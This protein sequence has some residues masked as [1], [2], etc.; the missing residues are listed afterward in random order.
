MDY[1]S[2]IASIENL[3]MAFRH[4]ASNRGGPGVDSV[5]IEDFQKNQEQ[6]IAQISHSLL[7]GTY[8][9]QPALGIEMHEKKRMVFVL[10]VSDRT[11][12]QA[13]SQ[14][15]A[16]PL[17]KYFH[18][19]CY[20]YRPGR[21]AV[22]AAEFLQKKL[23]TNQFPYILRCDI[24]KYFDHIDYKILFSFLDWALD[25]KKDD[26][27]RLISKLI[28]QKRV[29]YGQLQEGESGLCQGSSLSP[30][31]SNLYL[32]PLDRYLEKMGY[33]HV[34][35]CDDLTVLLPSQEEAQP[36]CSKISEF[37]EEYLKLKLHPDKL[38]LACFSQ[39]FDFLGFHFSPQGRVPSQKAQDRLSD[40]VQSTESQEE[41]Q[42]A[43]QHWEA[44]YGKGTASESANSQASYP[45]FDIMRSLFRGNSEYF[46]RAYKTERRYEYRAKS[47]KITDEELMGH[48][49]GN[50]TLG[51]YLLD[52]DKVAC[53]CLDLDIE[54]Q[55]MDT[56]FHNDA[57][58]FC[59]YE[60]S[61]MNHTRQIQKLLQE[62]GLEALMER[63][64][65][66]GYHLWL[67][68]EKFVPASWAIALWK[69]VLAQVGK[70]PQGIQR[71]IFP[72]EPQAIEDLGSLIKIPLGLHPG[73][74]LRSIF[75][76]HTGDAISN[77]QG[78][79][80]NAQRISSDQLNNLISQERPA[81]KKGS[82]IER[83]FQGCNVVKALCHKAKQKS[84]LGHFERT[85][86]LYTIGQLGKAGEEFLH[87]IISHCY[88]YNKAYT[89]KQ[90]E[91]KHPAPIGCRK[92]QEIM[93]ESLQN[94]E[95]HCSFK[96][97]QGGYA[98]PLLH[99]YPDA[100]KNLGRKILRSSL[101]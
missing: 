97:P 83:L 72:R 66:K 40:K 56:F 53:T 51:L 50:H 28:N 62:I 12:S 65:Y 75:L 5:K 79:L 80:Q 46:A 89:Q 41:K 22:Q 8:Q 60:D 91:K 29:Y 52:K 48:L 43:I 78:L 98:S 9:F 2:K 37:L 61:I 15:L 26:T 92:I 76:D 77:P 74:G 30:L 69:Q 55:I 57:A 27:F 33:V 24:Y 99:V 31:L 16:N 96:T 32:T 3:T 47:G 35:F 17:E 95:C 88:N 70:S 93:G 19:A 86:L 4:I 94:I 90:I 82:E 63:S 87:S 81:I 39:G 38:E 100:T 23:K 45:I 36:L 68:F 54:K 84:N 42:K 14:V 49:L 13:I 1:L 34:R 10:T 11:V 73:S 67:F 85:I 21:S 59:L 20:S 7:H 64:G 44:Y 101:I 25:G 71:E 58:R 18:N 6:N